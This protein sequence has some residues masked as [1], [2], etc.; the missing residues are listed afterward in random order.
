MLTPA[1][2]D[3]FASFGAVTV[4]SPYTAAELD[5]ASSA[6]DRFFPAEPASWAGGER[7]DVPMRRADIQGCAL[8]ELVP[9]IEHPFLEAAACA[10]LGVDR[11]E[12]W[13]T[14]LSKTYPTPGTEFRFWEHVDLKYRLEDLDG[15][16]RRMLCSCWVW[17]TDVTRERAPMM[18]RPGSHRVIAEHRSRR[19]DLHDGPNWFG[20]LPELPFAEP[21]PVLAR[22]GQVSVLTTAAVHGASTCTGT[23]DRKGLVV[24]FW[25]PGMV[26]GWAVGKRPDYIPSLIELRARMSPERRHLVPDFTPAGAVA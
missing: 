24:V 25:S 7:G 2:I 9:L 4:D 23:L 5:H 14:A 17:L 22:R 13:A 8:P 26:S 10:A 12:I 20:E 16:P 11:V 21:T 3:R 18:Y 6:I 15:S 19:G 1:Q